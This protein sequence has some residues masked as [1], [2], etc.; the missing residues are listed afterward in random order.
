M[1]KLTLDEVREL[2]FGIKKFIKSTEFILEG[3]LNEKTRKKQKQKQKKHKK[4]KQVQKSKNLFS[5]NSCD[6]LF[7]WPVLGHVGFPL[8]I[9]YGKY[10]NRMYKLVLINPNTNK[11]VDELLNILI[12]FWHKHLLS[13]NKHLLTFDTDQLSLFHFTSI[14]G[15]AKC[16]CL[17]V[18]RWQNLI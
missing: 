8:W 13:Y 2:S 4:K 3:S 16:N 14:G 1:L 12:N 17:P 15:V 11:L 18:Q 9:P 6:T 7:T 10:L 5:S